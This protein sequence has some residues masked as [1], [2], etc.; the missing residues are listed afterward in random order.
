[1]RSKEGDV[2]IA[3]LKFLQQKKQKEEGDGNKAVVAFFFLLWR[4]AAVQ[5]KRRHWQ[6]CRHLFSFF[7][8]TVEETKGRRR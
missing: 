7:A 4:C 3:F 5:R 2:V 6:R 1:L 8:A